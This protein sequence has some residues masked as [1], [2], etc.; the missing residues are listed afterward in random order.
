MATLFGA[1][2][3]L[4]LCAGIM[5]PLERLFPRDGVR[6]SPSDAFACAA[7]FVVNV[8]LMHAIGGSL[9]ASAMI[10]PTWGPSS[11]PALLI[12]ALVLGDLAGYLVH[13]AMHR[14]PWLWRLHRVHHDPVL[15]SWMEAWRV[16]PV[17]FLLHG[18]AVGLPGALMGASLSDVVALV[19]V[20][21]AWTAFLHADVH[22][23]C[24]PLVWIIA[25]PEFHSRHH[26]HD[27][28]HHGRNFSGTFPLWDRLFGTYADSRAPD[29]RA[30]ADL[31]SQESEALIIGIQGAAGTRSPSAP[32]RG[33]IHTA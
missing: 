11:A 7:L 9:L 24:G 3:F 19:L 15:L 6:Q 16:H 2:L 4:V 22:I 14:V 20:R 21:R 17:D 5:I 25:T 30:S 10:A 8:L 23:P 12:A 29:A 32:R 27:P 26:S 33:T 13:R 1:I 31:G 18:L 28:R